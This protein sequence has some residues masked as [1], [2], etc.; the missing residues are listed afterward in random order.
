MAG[1]SAVRGA[2]PPVAAT[3]AGSLP[4][5]A[6]LA[7]PGVLWPAWRLPAE[8]LAEGIRDAVRLAV[9]DQE[10]AGL[11]LLSD[12]E[13]PRRH[14]V[15]AFLEGLD[16]VDPAR[17]VT[18]GIRG[19]RYRAEVPTVVGP[20]RRT[21]PV[22]G[23]EVRWLR[24]HTTRGVKFTLPGPVT[25]ADTVADLHYRDRAAL[26]LDL[27]TAINT[28]ARELAALGA[29]VIQLDE[30]AFNVDAYAAD[31]RAWG[32]AALDR[33]LAGLPCRTGIHIC[34]GYGIRA[35]VEWKAG[36]GRE[37]RQY[38]RTFPLLA[39]AR[40]DQV[41]IECAGSRV[42]LE[43]VGLLGGKAVEV[44][45]IDVASDRVETAEEVAATL[46]RA[47]AFVPPDRLLASTNCGMAPLGREVARA[48]LAAL[49][50]GA[51]RVR[52][53]LGHA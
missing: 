30:P 49:G 4:K 40:V 22:H 29:D 17:R 25:A 11:D 28:E 47:L 12:G 2:L 52:A 42:P 9:R 36:L 16:G 15:H 38:E 33:A 10:V 14:F 43:L 34:Y 44:G 1:S 6:W 8:T 37:W 41:S 21:R 24:A 23:D 18:I 27:A 7:A 31:I 51:A 39:G 3:L 19:D 32:M 26:A 13:Q 35:N 45:V 53:E 48:K 50:Q 5:P 20:V 46:R